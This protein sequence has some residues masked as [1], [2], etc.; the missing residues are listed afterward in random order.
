MPR[1]MMTVLLT[2][3]LATPAGSLAAQEES[4]ADRYKPVLGEWEMT[5]E[6]PRG[7][8]T[9]QFVFTLD[10]DVL[11]GT[12]ESQRGSFDL[13]NVSFEGGRLTFELERSF[14]DRS[15][16]QSFTATIEGDEMKGTFSGG[17]GGDRPYTATRKK[18]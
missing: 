8:F 14:G 9:Q 2:A 16:T 18:T 5:M 17:R 13:K 11:K 4:A 10:G 7:S 6:T 3:A 12:V 1:S 15:F